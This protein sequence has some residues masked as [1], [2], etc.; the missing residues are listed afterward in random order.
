MQNIRTIPQKGVQY[1]QKRC[2]ACQNNL[3]TFLYKIPFI[4]Y[5]LSVAQMGLI[6]LKKSF[7]LLSTKMKAG[8]SST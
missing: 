5:F 7:P 4:C 6:C 1:K 3:Y 2:T 8:K